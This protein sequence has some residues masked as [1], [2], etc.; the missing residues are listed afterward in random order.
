ME[1]AGADVDQTFEAQV[2]PSLDL[3]CQPSDK[4]EQ[5]DKA[6][7]KNRIGN[8]GP[9]PGRRHRKCQGCL[10]AC[11]GSDQGLHSQDVV[12]WAKV[13]ELRRTA[14]SC[15]NPFVARALKQHLERHCVAKGDAGCR[16]KYV[17]RVVGIRE[18]SDIPFQGRTGFGR[19][20]GAGLRL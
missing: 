5:G 3:R 6:G 19:S 16:E 2:L 13:V 9:V 1:L 4:N 8:M 20:P 7:R 14:F 11:V 10:V 12:S 15:R 18:A 17:K